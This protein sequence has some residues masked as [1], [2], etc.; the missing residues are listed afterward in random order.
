[1]LL[2]KVDVIIQNILLMILIIKNKNIF[3]LNKLNRKIIKI[4]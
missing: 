2:Y 1:M 3:V 4:K